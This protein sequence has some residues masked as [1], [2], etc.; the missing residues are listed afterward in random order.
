MTTTSEV[1]PASL[2][3]LR[4]A[5][6]ATLA[7]GVAVSVTANVL[8]ARDEL[9]AQAIA[10]WPPL[11]LLITVDLVSRVPIHRRALGAVRIVATFAIAAIAAFI[12]YGHMAGVAAKFGESGLVPYLL[13]LSVDGLVVV[14]SVSLVELAGRLRATTTISA[15]TS[16]PADATRSG[17]TRPVQ[18]EVP[19]PAPSV[20]SGRSSTV[21]DSEILPQCSD[22]HAEPDNHRPDH[23]DTDGPEAADRGDDSP[24]DEHPPP[25]AESTGLPGRPYRAPTELAD[26]LV[27]LLGAA[28]Q[29]RDRL[30]DE[31]RAVTRDALAAQL[32]ADGHAIRTRR[33]AELLWAL[34]TE[35]A[36][37]NG[38]HP[39]ASEPS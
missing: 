30:L 17:T 19:T 13:P 3:R 2:R 26:D 20:Q 7:L 25:S 1:S 11:A 34:K 36:P 4:W 6:R 21:A 38:R 8:H 23:T 10:A 27:P 39:S 22:Q 14:A 18:A 5:V 9:I 35:S 29:A 33:V 16:H 31:G 15:E 32:R 28:R 12:S 24:G 37:T